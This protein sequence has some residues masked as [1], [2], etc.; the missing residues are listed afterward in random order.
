MK[1]SPKH[2]LRFLIIIGLLTSITLVGLSACQ[3][4]TKHVQE[5]APAQKPL[6]DP[7]YSLAEDRKEFEKLREN[8]PERKKQINDE[9]ALYA[10]WTAGFRLVPNDVREKFE[11]LTR[12]KRELFNKDMTAAREEVSKVEKQQRDAVLKELENERID[13]SKRK[14][15]R[16]E[17]NDFY[18]HQDDKRRRYFADERD[19]REEFESAARDQRRNFEDYLKEKS[20]EFAS[21]LKSYTESWKAQSKTHE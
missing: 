12:K 21:E 14:K 7:K 6:V 20:L 17:R 3:L 13:F 4:E 15:E 10:E 16:D 8:I 5:S 18:N 19:K 2:A 1:Q 11:N 9:K